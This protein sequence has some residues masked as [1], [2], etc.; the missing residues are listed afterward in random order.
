[1]S[2]DIRRYIQEGWVDSIVSGQNIVGPYFA[3]QQISVFRQYARPDQKFYFWS[4]MVDY[5][6][7]RVFPIEDLIKQNQF[8][9]FYGANGAMFH[10]SINFEEHD[11][12]QK[13]LEP[14]AEFFRKY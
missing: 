1:M 6:G 4:Q 3:A 12:P 9:K 11:A 2:V 7:S 13:Y 5:A 8:F 10:E 14:I